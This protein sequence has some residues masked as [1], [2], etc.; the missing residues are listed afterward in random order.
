V[1]AVR[2]AVQSGGKDHGPFLALQRDGE[3]VDRNTAQVQLT[4]A[5]QRAEPAAEV[6]TVVLGGPS[7]AGSPASGSS[8]AGHGRRRSG[9]GDHRTVRQLP[10][11]W[12]ATA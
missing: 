4:L 5:V 2:D 9:R 7:S 8:G 1:C 10:S 11:P 6:V 3:Q 12:A